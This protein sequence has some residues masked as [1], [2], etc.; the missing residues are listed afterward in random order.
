MNKIMKGK[1][2]VTGASGFIGQH[3]IKTLKLKGWEIIALVRDINSYELCEGEG[4][5]CIKG[6]IDDINPL[7]EVISQ[8]DS[9]CHLAAYIP[10]DYK[11]PVF[12]KKCIWINGLGT[13]QLALL[14]SKI[15]GLRFVYFSSANAYTNNGHAAR[16]DSLF[17]PSA[18]ATYYLTSKL[19]GEIYVER[20]RREG[21]LDAVCLRLSS[22]YG[23]GMLEQSV[24]YNYMSRASQG[25]PLEVWDNGIPTYD[26]VYVT[27]VVEMATCALENGRLG[28]YNVG[29][30]YAT[31][32]LELAERVVATFPG[33]EIAIRIKPPRGNIPAS[34]PALS[35]KK[36]TRMWEFSPLSLK[37][38]LAEYRK[39]MG[40]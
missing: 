16:E 25:Q 22:V 34:F 19:V 9:V 10:P 29:S 18:R 35:I 12:A 6:D 20:L 8:V 32:V 1:V 27:D 4:I 33:K 13:L 23:P 40:W 36:A 17:Y 26:F 30:G 31:S 5:K 2:L 3:L 21:Q 14:V 15:Q 37:D 39:Q 28:I 38:G 7:K 24:V 11:D